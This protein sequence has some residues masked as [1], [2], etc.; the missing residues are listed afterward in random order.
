VSQ[1][2]SLPRFGQDQVRGD[3]ERAHGRQEVADVHRPGP[4]PEMRI[5]PATASGTATL[6]PVVTRCP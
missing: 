1:A 3:A 2:T 6:T 4:P 5:W